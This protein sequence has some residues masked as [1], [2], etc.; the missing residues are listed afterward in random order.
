MNIRAANQLD[1]E[2]IA[3]VAAVLGYGRPSCSDVAKQLAEIESSTHIRAW[4]CQMGDGV[5]GWVNAE[6][7]T[8]LASEP[9]IEIV[10]LA[11]ASEFQNKGIGS[12]LVKEVACWADSL[13]LDLRV[14]TNENRDQA[15]KFYTKC[16]FTKI[17]NQN[18]FQRKT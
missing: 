4:V 12:K 2:D 5:V 3:K 13:R 17:K 8:R 16:G 15:I 11:V 14:R 18:V 7:V 6:R 10:G 9:F 1:A